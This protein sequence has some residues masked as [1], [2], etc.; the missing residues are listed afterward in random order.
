[1]RPLLRLVE[2]VETAAVEDELEWTI[3]QNGGEKILCCEA[4]RE[5]AAIQLRRG[6]FDR[7]RGDIDAQDVEAA[8]R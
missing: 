4:A 7:E 2:D 5:S 3:R 8:L 1:M 6:T